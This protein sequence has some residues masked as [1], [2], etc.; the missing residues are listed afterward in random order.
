M[1]VMAKLTLTV[2]YD[3]ASEKEAKELLNTLVNNASNEGMLSGDSAAITVDDFNY[4][5]TAEPT[6]LIK[7]LKN[8]S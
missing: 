1:K 2:W 8:I 6:F 7:K 5:I 4:S 3:G